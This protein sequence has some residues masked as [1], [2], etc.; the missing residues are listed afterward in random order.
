[1]LN[2]LSTDWQTEDTVLVCDNAPCHNTLEAVEES[3]IGFKLL[4]LARYSPML[5]LI[6]NLSNK[7]KAK[8]KAQ[9]QLTVSPVTPPIL[10]EQRLQYVFSVMS[11]VAN[12]DCSNSAQHATLFYPAAMMVGTKKIFCFVKI[13][14]SAIC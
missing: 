7:V 3:F 10:G 5:S 6:E 1:M 12:E 9:N 8:V 2:N 11:Q 13:F 14:L 4:R